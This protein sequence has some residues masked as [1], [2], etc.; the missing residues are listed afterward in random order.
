MF[1]DVILALVHSI[2]VYD[3]FWVFN[4]N[5]I[6]YLSGKYFNQKLFQFYLPNIPKIVSFQVWRKI[7]KLLIKSIDGASLLQNA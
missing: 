4:L 1:V 6:Q 5:K 3:N 2:V 7:K